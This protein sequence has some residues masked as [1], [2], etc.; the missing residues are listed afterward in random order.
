M[1]VQALRDREELFVTVDHQ[2]SGIDAHA[3]HIGQQHV[4]H[5]GDTA[6]GRRGVDAHNG[7]AERLT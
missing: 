7:A 1:I 6:P 3:A 5:L 4:Q 2:P